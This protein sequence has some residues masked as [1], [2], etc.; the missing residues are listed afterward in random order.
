MEFAQ[1]RIRLLEEIRGL[2][3]TYSK[4]P[5]IIKTLKDIVQNESNYAKLIELSKVIF[6]FDDAIKNLSY[7]VKTISSSFKIGNEDVLM[8]YII[9]SLPAIY[10]IFDFNKEAVLK[11]I[12]LSFTCNEYMYSNNSDGINCVFFDLGDLDTLI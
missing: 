6:S 1:L 8:D 2:E 12:N 4:Y 11:H 5:E 10:C 3:K 9:S 7:E